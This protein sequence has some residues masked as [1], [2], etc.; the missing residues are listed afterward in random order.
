MKKKNFKAIVSLASFLLL[1]AGFLTAGEPVQNQKRNSLG[2]KKQVQSRIRILFVDENGDGI[3]DF[4][5]DHDN[6]GIP[7]GQD[8][9]WTK[10]GDATGY[11]N[12]SGGS[13]GAGAM[14]AARNQFRGTRG[15]GLNKQSFRGG[16]SGICGIGS[17][18]GL[19]GKGK[20]AGNK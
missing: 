20:R 19:N 9:D 5:T 3:C 6:D 4:F 17:G 7:N 11:Q 14:T 18:S 13:T 12:K 10:P 16:A 1:A 8:P 2:E 15:L